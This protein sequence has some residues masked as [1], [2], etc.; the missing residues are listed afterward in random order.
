MLVSALTETGLCACFYDILYS[1]QQT[2]T[3]LS[4]RTPGNSSSMF[5][6]YIYLDNNQINHLRKSY[7]IMGLLSDC[8]G[9]ASTVI[10]IFSYIV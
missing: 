10:I 2:V 1:T 3:P 4:I 9:M 8:G 6:W 5:L 7:D